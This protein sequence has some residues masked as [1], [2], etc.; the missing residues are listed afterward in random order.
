MRIE[1]RCEVGFTDQ[2]RVAGRG[3]LE[4]EEIPY[5]G[6]IIILVRGVH[7]NQDPLGACKIR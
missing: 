5:P 3:C 1:K 2:A 4:A 6:R 7:E